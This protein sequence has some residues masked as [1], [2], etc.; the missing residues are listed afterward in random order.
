MLVAGCDVGS[1]TGKAVI[2][3]DGEILA[4]SIV[5]TTPKPQITAQNAMDAALQKK[6]LSLNDIEF[7]VGTGYGRIKIPFANSQISE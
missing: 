7:I 2:L 6:N 3:Q 1:L 4:Y 5:P